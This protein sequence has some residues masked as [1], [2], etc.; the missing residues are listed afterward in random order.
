MTQTNTNRRTAWCGEITDDLLAYVN[1]KIVSVVSFEI[2]HFKYSHQFTSSIKY[3]QEN[4]R[5][6]EMEFEE[7]EVEKI[8]GKRLIHGKVRIFV[9]YHLNIH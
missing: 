1:V 4:I 8:F 5:C 9:L 3:S 7:V 2:E 6:T